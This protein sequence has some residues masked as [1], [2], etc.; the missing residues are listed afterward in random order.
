MAQ[1][2]ASL[3]TGVIYSLS[4][5]PSS[6]EIQALS[7]AFGK[8]NVLDAFNLIDHGEGMY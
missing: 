4:K 7:L 1:E 2:L 8:K 3:H 5:L 6:S